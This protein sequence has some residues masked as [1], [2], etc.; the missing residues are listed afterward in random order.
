[1]VGVGHPTERTENYSRRTGGSAGHLH[2]RQA[3]HDGRKKAD[4]DNRVLGRRLEDGREYRYGKSSWYMRRLDKPLNRHSG[5]TMGKGE[6]GIAQRTSQWGPRTQ[7]KYRKM[8]EKAEEMRNLQKNKSVKPLYVQW[9]HEARDVKEA[10]TTC[11]RG[12]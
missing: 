4:K 2:D 3:M 6:N 1:M 5:R 12:V 9:P 8:P 10:N 11:Q 7:Q